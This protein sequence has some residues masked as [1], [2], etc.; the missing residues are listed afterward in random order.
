M[1]QQRQSIT[2]GGLSSRRRLCSVAKAGLRIAIVVCSFCV[3]PA[4]PAAQ[5]YPVQRSQHVGP[6]TTALPDPRE[7]RC[8]VGAVR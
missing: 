4:L 1:R 2:H 8:F 5:T 7:P 6:F 3:R